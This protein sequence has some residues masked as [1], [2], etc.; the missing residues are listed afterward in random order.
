MH[1]HI[2]IIMHHKYSCQLSRFAQECG[3]K[4]NAKFSVLG[5]EQSQKNSDYW[6]SG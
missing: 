2:N 1:M 3:V 4:R 6:S 5:L